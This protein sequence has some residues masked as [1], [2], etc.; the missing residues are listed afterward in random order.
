MFWSHT[1]IVHILYAVVHVSFVEQLLNV[2][3]GAGGVDVCLKMRGFTEISLTANI[4]TF[5]DTAVGM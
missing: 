3:E 1:Y 4:T 5:E 2:S